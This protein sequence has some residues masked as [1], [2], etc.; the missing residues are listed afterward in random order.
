MY[1]CKNCSNFQQFNWTTE[2]G[3][4]NFRGYSN[5]KVIVDSDSRCKYFS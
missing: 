3:F 1:K 2:K 4:C 5:G